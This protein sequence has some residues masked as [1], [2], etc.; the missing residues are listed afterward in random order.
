MLKWLCKTALRS[1]TSEPPG[2]NSGTGAPVIAPMSGS[3]MRCNQGG[4][5]EY[6]IISHP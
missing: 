3:A 6:V 5:V 1:T 2:G 4:T